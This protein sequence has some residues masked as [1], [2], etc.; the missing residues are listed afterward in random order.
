MVFVWYPQPLADAAG[1][2]RLPVF[3]A[4]AAV[5][6][7]PL[8][9]LLS[10][11]SRVPRAWLGRTRIAVLQAI[12]FAGCALTLYVQRPVYL[13]FTIDR[14]DLVLARDL[15]P[16]DLAKTA[17][18]QFRR[19]PMGAPQYV[20]AVQPAEPAEAQRILTSALDG[21]KDLQ[22]YPQHYVPYAQ[23]AQ[24]ALRRAKPITAALGKDPAAVESFLAAA[25]RLPASV[26]F[27]PLRARKRDGI[28]LL[29]ATS[30][31]PAGILLV[32]P[33]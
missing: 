1:T 19:R 31:L 21:G 17:R 5:T 26:K 9:A 14:F 24:N 23:E 28:V 25:G 33:W 8:A 7:G 4:V 13:V 32:D 16:R 30:G 18:E 12:V 15:D 29:D 3:L 27:L 11:R 22:A 20:A 6:L 10:G 2:A